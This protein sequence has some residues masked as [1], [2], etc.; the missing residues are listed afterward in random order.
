MNDQGA[1]TARTLLI[2]DHVWEAFSSMAME[3]GSERDSLVNQALY[4]FGSGEPRR[5]PAGGID[6]LR[7]AAHRSDR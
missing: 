5:R 6:R 4:T 3:M 7:P 1:K 2:A